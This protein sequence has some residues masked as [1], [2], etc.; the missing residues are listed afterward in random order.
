MKQTKDLC[1]LPC[2]AVSSTTVK[3]VIVAYPP[4]QGA[5]ANLSLPDPPVARSWQ[6]G[7]GSWLPKPFTCL[8]L[9][10]I[11]HLLTLQEV[12]KLLSWQQGDTTAS[13]ESL[14]TWLPTPSSH[15]LVRCSWRKRK[16]PYWC[17]VQPVPN[18]VQ[19]GSNLKGRRKESSSLSEG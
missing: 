12:G 16:K 2:A 14:R 7:Q 4:L 17:S 11:K 6:S 13:W 3:R 9:R 8:P 5:S 19:S 10:R 18:L 1:V 15:V